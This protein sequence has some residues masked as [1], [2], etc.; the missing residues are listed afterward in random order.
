MSKKKIKKKKGSNR[1]FFIFFLLIAIGGF[2][3]FIK[4]DFFI[5][6][7]IYVQGANTIAKEEILEISGV[8]TGDN[9][10]SF[11]A[12]E[13]QQAVMSIPN[14]KNVSV[15]R[16]YP[17][18]VKIIVVERSAFMV[19][20]SNGMYYA[21]DEE[22]NVLSA[23]EKIVNNEGVI[24][25]GLSEIALQEGEIYKFSSS[26]HT[27]TAYDILLYLKNESLYEYISELYITQGG[28]YYLYTKK[29]NIIKF[30]SLDAFTSNTEFIKEFLLY[31]NRSIMAEIVEGRPPVYQTI[32][33][34]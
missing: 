8:K 6:E 7:H 3:Y 27:Q 18:T 21:I 10:F 20:N 32:N 25:S 24:I 12:T 26:V 13:V 23:D 4:S 17:N 9:I 31:E 22:G 33:L 34:N 11:K 2:I 19:I 1:I 30:Y 14:V 15:V 29:A 5:I 28:N 16:T